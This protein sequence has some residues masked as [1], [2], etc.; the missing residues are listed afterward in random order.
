MHTTP[1]S[2]SSNAFHISVTGEVIGTSNLVG[3]FIIACPS[4]SVTNRPWKGRG[5]RHVTKFKI[6]HLT[7]YVRNDQSYRLQILWAVCP[8]EVL[9]FRMTPLSG[10]GTWC[11]LEFQTTEISL[12]RLKPAES[13]NF[14]C[15]QAMSNVSLRT[16]DHPW[17]KGVRGSGH[18]I[19]FRIVHSLIKF[20]W[21][22]WRQNR[23][24]LCT[25]WPEKY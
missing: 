10:R 17:K 21:N 11:L 14:V 25:G 24:I 13:S 12:E 16:A 2:S 9:T 1:F 19:H 23:Q 7:K 5:Q 22:G 8:R 20:L 6:L 18:E 3:R 4:L 15:L